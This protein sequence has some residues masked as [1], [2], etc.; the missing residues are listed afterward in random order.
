VS[1][2]LSHAIGALRHVGVLFSLR[3]LPFGDLGDLRTVSDSAQKGWQRHWYAAFPALAWYL[4]AASAVR[5]VG[6]GAAYYLV[7]CLLGRTGSAR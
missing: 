2:V 5:L 7:V 3:L 4:G 6:V 1:F